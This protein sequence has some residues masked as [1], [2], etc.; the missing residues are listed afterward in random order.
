MGGRSSPGRARVAVVGLAGLLVISLAGV[1]W[2]YPVLPVA[3]CPACF[4]FE[5]HADDL[6]VHRDADAAAVATLR[7]DIA[8][9][10]TAVEATLGLAPRRALFVACPS[11][12]CDRR[13]GGKGARATVYSTPLG[14]VVRLGPGGWDR[15]ILTHEL[16]HVAVHRHV[17]ATR[18]LDGTLPA[19]FDEGIAVVVSRDERFVRFDGRAP[20]CV[21]PSRADLPVSAWEW[22]PLSGLGPTIYAHAAC[23]VVEWMEANGGWP[24]LR[25]ALDDLASGRRASLP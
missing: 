13:L 15:T 22:A 12:P 11:E 14:S 17:G 21:A 19:W 4:G 6:V 20:A 25:T 23:N 1:A 10:R 8:S 3:A 7:R 24:G 16:V 5:R 9:G 18:V 2:A